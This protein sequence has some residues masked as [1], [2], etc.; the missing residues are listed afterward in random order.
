MKNVTIALDEALLRA[1]RQVAA[2]RGT[3]LNALIRE[4]L[5]EL[6]AR[7]SRAAQA[8]RRILDLCHA[9]SGEVGPGGPRDELHDR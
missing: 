8:R 3:S 4:H 2:N 9:A 6:I 7:E 5:E 1:A